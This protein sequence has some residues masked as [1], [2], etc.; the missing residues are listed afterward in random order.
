MRS[1]GQ[2][3]NQMQ[4]LSMMQSKLPRSVLVKLEEMKPKGEEWTVEK[5]RR[6]LKRHINAQEAGDLQQNCFKKLMNH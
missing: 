5:F 1:L 4:V 6:L 2:D 3:D